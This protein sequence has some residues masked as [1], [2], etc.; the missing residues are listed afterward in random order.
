MG[1]ASLMQFCV[2]VDPESL[3][4]KQ[5]VIIGAGAFAVEQARTALVHGAKHVTIVAR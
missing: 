4:G 5:V 1:L 2:Q 3:V